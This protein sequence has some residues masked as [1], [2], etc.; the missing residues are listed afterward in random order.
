MKNLLMGILAL[1]SLQTFAFENKAVCTDL[2]DK[3]PGSQSPLEQR[4]IMDY[5]FNHKLSD[6]DKAFQITWNLERESFTKIIEV[7]ESHSNEVSDCLLISSKTNNNDWLKNMVKA[8]VTSTNSTQKAKKVRKTDAEGLFALVKDLSDKDI[9]GASHSIPRSDEQP[10][11]VNYN[12]GE[13]EVECYV[14][15]EET[16]CDVKY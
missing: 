9:D 12:N 14:E 7:V 11:M 6:L 15:L 5:C 10:E 4:D 16:I 3:L 8:C 13:L 2:L 1:L